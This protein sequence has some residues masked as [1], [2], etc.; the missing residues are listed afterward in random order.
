MATENVT[1]LVFDVFGTVVDWRSSI[2]RDLSAWGAEKGVSPDWMAL[3]DEW[4]TAYRPG[5]DAVNSG[6]RPWTPVGV[7]YREK[8]DELLPKYGLDDLN[9]EDRQYINECWYRLDPWADS[10][11]GMKRLADKYVLS[12]LSN[13]DFVGMVQMAKRAGIPFDAVL[14]AENA[15]MFKPDPSV[16]R[17][18]IDMLGYGVPENVMLVAA[19]NYDLTHARSHGMG[20]AFIPRLTEYGPDQTTDLEP[21]QEWDVIASSMED[22]A[23]KLG[24]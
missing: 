8:L 9:E 20:T 5:M 2:D 21:E 19:H 18:A 6:E 14:T 16:Y 11:P 23:D 7:I 22:L 1:T 13:S 12:S 10:L 17:M 3:I 15:K 24:C 4:K